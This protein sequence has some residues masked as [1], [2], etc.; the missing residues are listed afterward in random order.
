MET[1][2]SNYKD[3]NYINALIF[4]NLY[5]LPS[6]IDAVVGIP[7]SG[8]ITAAI[9]AEFR[10]LP[11]TDLFSFIQGNSIKTKFI[12]HEGSLSK[13]F[14][15]SSVKHILLVDDTMGVGSTMKNAVEMVKESNHDIKITTFV[16]FVEPFSTDKVD[17]YCEVMRHQFMP[18][19]VLKRAIQFSC[20]DMDG[21]LT[22]EVP[23][24]YDTD[25]EKYIDFISNQRPIYVPETPI[26]IIVTGRLIKYKDVTVDWL[27]RHNIQFQG[28]VMLNLPDKDARDSF[29]VGEY[30]GKV[31]LQSNAGLFIESNYNEAR[32]IKSVANKPVYC[33]QICNMI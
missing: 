27:K 5:R 8:M 28:I 1:V 19:S 25:D 3:Y 30:K 22:E 17:I 32:T 31:Y 29:N 15:Y 21:V 9:I 13:V 24:E 2:F 23:H 16:T 18:Y 6:D 33:T 4:N 26:G 14:D 20:V 7:R 10:S 12:N 11:L